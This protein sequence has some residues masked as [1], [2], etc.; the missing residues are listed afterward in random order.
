MESKIN[1]HEGKDPSVTIEM[2]SLPSV[3]GQQLVF[4]YLPPDTEEGTRGLTRDEFN[5]MRDGFKAHS[6]PPLGYASYGP[7]PIFVFEI[8]KTIRAGALMGTVYGAL[9]DREVY[10]PWV[11]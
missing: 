8:A 9:M 7:V 11:R 5:K 3:D 4:V 1:P 2:H 10:A 6:W